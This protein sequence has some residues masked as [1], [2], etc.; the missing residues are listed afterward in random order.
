[1]WRERKAIGKSTQGAV[2][3]LVYDSA[4]S[5]RLSDHKP[6]YALLDVDMTILS[7]PKQ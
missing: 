3:C 7:M 5:C 4:W 6:V 1:M 2:R